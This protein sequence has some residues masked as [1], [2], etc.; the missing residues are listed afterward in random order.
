[1]EISHIPGQFVGALIVIFAVS[2][3]LRR[4]IISF[5]RY[6]NRLAST[7]A[8]FAGAMILTAIGYSRMGEISLII[9][10]LAGL[11]VWCCL[12]YELP[13]SRRSIKKDDFQGK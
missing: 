4:A 5:L 9:Y 8:S 2:W 3:F 6:S 11:I 13:L 12:F 7:I 1:M 10:P